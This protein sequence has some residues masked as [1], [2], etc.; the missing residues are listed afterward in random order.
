MRTR[1]LIYF[2]AVVK[3]EVARL[4]AKQRRTRKAEVAGDYAGLLRLVT[5]QNDFGG[6]E[7]T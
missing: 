6:G 2:G 3:Q 1:N 5:G 7:G 4:L